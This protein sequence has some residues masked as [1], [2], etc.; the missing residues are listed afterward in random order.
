MV[1]IYGHGKYRYSLIDWAHYM[2]IH[3]IK[4]VFVAAIYYHEWPQIMIRSLREYFDEEVIL[5]NHLNM[6]IPSSYIDK[7]CTILTNNIGGSHGQAIDKAVK[8]LKE[9]R[10]DYFVHIEPDCLISGREWY[11]HLVSAAIN[12]ATMAGPHKLPFGPIHP[13]PSIWYVPKIHGSFEVADRSGEID[14]NLLDTN[15]MVKWLHSNNI[16]EHGI[17]I[18][19]NSWDCGIKNWYESAKLNRAFHTQSSEGFKHFFFGR[20]RKPSELPEDEYSLVRKYLA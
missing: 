15:E 12:G 4:I 16:K 3:G 9:R 13:C 19:M 5:V 20:S 14:P 10:I 18:W 8:Y 11:D 6:E 7:N 1:L 2:L 17:R